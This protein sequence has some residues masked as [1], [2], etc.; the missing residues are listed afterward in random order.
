MSYLDDELVRMQKYA[1]GLGIKV[2]R[3]LHKRGCPGAEWHTDGS[4]ITIYQWPRQAKAT[5]L[6]N[7]LHELA[8]HAAYVYSGRK[9]HSLTDRALLEED[10]RKETD[11]PLAKSKRRLIYE[12]EKND[13][14]WREIIHHELNLKLPIWKVRADV[15][16]DLWIYKRYYVTGNYPKQRDVDLKQEKLKKK[17]K[18]RLHVG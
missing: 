6:L 11:P 3:K 4:Q 12:T 8:H 14:K 2:S 9:S 1:E 7:F 15:E 18:A 17:W 13:S 5:L 10:A 16:L